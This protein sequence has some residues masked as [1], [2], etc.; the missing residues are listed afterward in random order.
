[1]EKFQQRSNTA[2]H[3]EDG[4]FWKGIL[5]GVAKHK[6]GTVA[7]NNENTA[8]ANGTSGKGRWRLLEGE[9]V[10]KKKMLL[11][12]IYYLTLQ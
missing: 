3:T 6:T 2:I 9:M 7:A 11:R 8:V 4:I 10:F 12:I 5:Q 1:M